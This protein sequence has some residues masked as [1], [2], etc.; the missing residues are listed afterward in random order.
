MVTHLSERVNIGH[1]EIFT[2]ADGIVHVHA[3]DHTYSL[4]D[5]KAIHKAINA[6]TDNKKS[7]ALLINSNYTLIDNEAKRFL[8][9]PE[10]AVNFIANAYVIKSLA[11]RLILNFIIRVKGTP[12]PANFFTE[13]SEAIAWLKSF[14]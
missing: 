6:L 3:T 5:I 9:S 13:K 4:A 14:K 2:D 7:L 10:A 12:V 8:S 1:T 11:H